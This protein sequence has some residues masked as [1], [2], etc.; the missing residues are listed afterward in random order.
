[1]KQ[2]D[3]NNRLPDSTNIEKISQI[4]AGQLK[5]ENFEN[6]YAK[7]KDVLTLV[8]AGVFCAASFA[9]PNLPKAL[10]PFL[11]NPDEFETWKRFN[12]PYLKRTLNRLEAR[13]LIEVIMEPDGQTV[14]ITSAGKQKILKYSLDEIK[15]EK[16]KNWDFKWRLV[17]YDIPKEYKTTRNTINFYLQKWHFYPL[18]KSVFLHAYP[19]EPQIEFLRELLGLGKY[20]RIFSVA[21]IEND[22]QFRDFFEV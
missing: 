3:S 11:K 1:M 19:C 17:C 16:P 8:G 18:Q 9:L 2:P 22:K 15:I 7:A 5:K 21:K 14:K 10:K 12:I 4:L 13:K 6:K 20:I